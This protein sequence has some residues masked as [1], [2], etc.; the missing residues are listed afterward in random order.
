MGSRFL[1]VLNALVNGL[2]AVLGVSRPSTTKPGP[3]IVSAA[4]AA[5][6]VPRE[7]AGVI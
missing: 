2:D 5:A 6:D 7:A 3:R 4:A 1:I